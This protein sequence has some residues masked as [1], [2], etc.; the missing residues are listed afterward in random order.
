MS[1]FATTPILRIAYEDGGPK[2][3][4]PVLL[5]H[6]WPDD[7]RTYDAVVPALQAAG[8]FHTS[9]VTGSG[10]ARRASCTMPPSRWP[11]EN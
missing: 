11:T 3:G 4:P 7:P 1:Q 8:P 2:D 10:R 6:G 9:V 5:L